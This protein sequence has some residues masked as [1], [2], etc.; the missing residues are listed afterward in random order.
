MRRGYSHGVSERDIWAQLSALP[1]SALARSWQTG[2]PVQASAL[3]ARWWQLETWLRSLAYVE[4]RARFGASWL[5]Q[6]PEKAARHARQEAQLAYMP[7]PDAELLLSYLDV[8][9][10]FDLLERQWDL[11][12]HALIDK[13]VWQGRVR[14]L[15][16]IRHRI[17]HCRR[18]HPD[19]LR[20]V[21]QTLRDLEPGGLRAAV[22]FNDREVPARDLDDPV[23]EGW[24]R[25]AHPDARRLVAHAESSYDISFRLGFSRRPW[26]GSYRED[27]AISGREGYLWHAIFILH[28]DGIEPENLWNDHYL[29]KPATRD[30]LVL[31]CM[32][33][34]HVV[35][36]SFAT[37]DD[38]K[39]ISDAIGDCFDAVINASR[40]SWEP[41]SLADG[42]DRWRERAAQL[43][44]R[45]QTST[46]WA[47]ADEPGT[48]VSLFQAG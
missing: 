1:R 22:S 26:A 40:M 31:L 11:F 39:A 35:N 13:T 3:H 19:D 47:L 48:P 43:D 37:V 36:A 7:S 30:R 32:D 15:R 41:G 42:L 46:S 16:Q 23:V 5:G 17:A 29:T 27:Q 18:P 33:T 20:R 28:S 4:L 14:E 24:L 9:D 25:E 21:E 45:V 6:I 38:P 10:L 8:F 2:V 44:P 34:P 12:S